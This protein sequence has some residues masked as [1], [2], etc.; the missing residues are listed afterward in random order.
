MICHIDPFLCGKTLTYMT[1]SNY[2]Y[3]SFS[4]RDLNPYI[5]TSRS[6]IF[7]FKC[8]FRTLCVS[9]II[10]L[11]I[12]LKGKAVKLYQSYFTSCFRI[13]IK[14]NAHNTS[15]FGLP[16][17]KNLTF[18]HTLKSKLCIYLKNNFSLIMY[19]NKTY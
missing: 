14:F 2:L 13:T 1:L 15:I 5:K 3:G 9:A 18:Q 11:L 16:I 6:K 12:I 8:H 10:L 7:L 17:F 4:S 19:F